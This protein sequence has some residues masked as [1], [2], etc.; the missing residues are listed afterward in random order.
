M[1]E[2][3]TLVEVAKLENEFHQLSEYVGRVH[4]EILEVRNSINIVQVQQPKQQPAPD[5]VPQQAAAQNPSDCMFGQGAISL[6]DLTTVSSAGQSNNLG[7]SMNRGLGRSTDTL[8]FDRI[9]EH[10]DDYHELAEK[11]TKLGKKIK[12]IERNKFVEFHAAID[13]MAKQIREELNSRFALSSRSQQQAA[14]ELK[15]AFQGQFTV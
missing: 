6:E 9:P 11:I 5:I 8:N 2:D 3:R 12:K 13:D 1:V 10:S 14:L 4:A 15:N 7:S